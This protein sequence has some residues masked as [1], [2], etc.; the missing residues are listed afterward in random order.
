MVPSFYYLARVETSDEAEEK[1]VST[2]DMMLSGV[3]WEAV[4]GASEKEQEAPDLPH[5][6][7]VGRL[8]ICPELEL[9]CFQLSDGRR[10]FPQPEFEK[11]LAWLESR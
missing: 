3:T 10:V 7:R 11:F 5:V 2:I 4:P 9:E 1:A 8:R 6:T